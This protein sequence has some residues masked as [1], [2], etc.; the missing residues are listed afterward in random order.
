MEEN[1]PQTIK[2]FGNIKA[3]QIRNAPDYPVQNLYPCAQ[4]PEPHVF[5]LLGG[6]LLTEGIIVQSDGFISYAPAMVARMKMT[7]FSVVTH[8][9]AWNEACEYKLR[10][11]YAAKTGEFFEQYSAAVKAVDMDKFVFKIPLEHVDRNGWFTCVLH[12]SLL[13]PMPAGPDR[14]AAVTAGR[15]SPT[16]PV[17]VRGSYLE[18]KG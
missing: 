17:V 3:S 9:D 11:V 10:L 16:M 1:H 12:V 2:R 18:I 5:W 7:K 4:G 8:I 13:T 15:E 6:L 14:D